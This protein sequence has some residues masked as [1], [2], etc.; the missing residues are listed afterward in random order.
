MY[1]PPPHHLSGAV[2]QRYLQGCLQGES[3]HFAPNKTLTHNSHVF[4]FFFSRQFWQPTKG[5]YNRFFSFASTLPG[6]G[7]LVPVEASCTRLPPCR[8][9]TNSDESL[10]V[11]RSPVLVNNPQFYLQCITSTCPPPQLKDILGGAHPAERYEGLTERHCKSRL[12][13]EVRG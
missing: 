9:Q 11:L 13:V 8:V 12:S 10:P 3:P 4:F 5:I 6:V 7:T 2:P 1:R